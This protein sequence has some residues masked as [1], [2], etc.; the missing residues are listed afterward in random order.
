MLVGPVT[1]QC[2]DCDTMLA[3]RS[4]QTSM[5]RC[6]GSDILSHNACRLFVVDSH[7]TWYVEDEA[8]GIFLLVPYT[9]D[10]TALT[11]TVVG[12]IT[13]HRHPVMHE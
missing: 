3:N 1:V 12:D 4:S 9:Q 7:Y 10:A 5:D 13:M 6:T 2:N 11:P 8:V